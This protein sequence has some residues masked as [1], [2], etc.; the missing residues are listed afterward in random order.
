MAGKG[1]PTALPQPTSALRVIS[2][3]YMDFD[4]FRKGLV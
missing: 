3:F 4:I 1:F 2:L